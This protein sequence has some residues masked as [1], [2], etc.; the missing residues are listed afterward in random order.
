MMNNYTLV[1]LAAGKGSRFGGLKQLHTFEPQGATLAE[2]ALWD[3]WK[4]NFRNFIA[5]VNEETEEGFQAIFKKW[6]LENR[7]KCILQKQD[8]GIRQKPW[9]TGHA[10]YVIR[11]HVHTP[12]VVINADDFYGIDAYRYAVKFFQSNDK[13]FALVGYPLRKTLSPYGSV[14]RALCEINEQHYVTHLSEFSHIENNNGK[15]IGKQGDTS[16]ILQM[17]NYV[18]LNFWILQPSI[19]KYLEGEWY[20]FLEHLSD[21]Q[22]DEF[23]LPVVVQNIA[24]RLNLQ[25]HCLPNVNGQWLGVTYAKDVAWVQNALINFTKEKQYPLN[26]IQAR[27]THDNY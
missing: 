18:S 17:E 14:S 9:G 12:F 23:Y 2:F 5:V 7:S 11:E 13:D 21:S 16:C 24:Q 15:I 20:E 8:V 3:A 10:L 19:F 4:C 25:I 26:F 1:L 22:K 6:G 27:N